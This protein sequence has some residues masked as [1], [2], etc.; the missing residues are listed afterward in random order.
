MF[1]SHGIVN[2]RARRR[3]QPA[4]GPDT[5]KLHHAQGMHAW[6]KGNHALELFNVKIQCLIVKMVSNAALNVVYCSS[7]LTVVH[8]R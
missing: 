2:A 7:R 3:R 6:A 1:A 4:Q 8:V 5:E